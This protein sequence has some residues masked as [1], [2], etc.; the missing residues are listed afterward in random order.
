M[1]R[2]PYQLS[3]GGAPRSRVFNKKVRLEI[4]RKLLGEFGSSPRFLEDGCN[5]GKF[6][7]CADRASTVGGVDDFDEEEEGDDWEAVL[8]EGGWDRVHSR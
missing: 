5:R 1:G 3:Y 4:G 8:E 7:R 2:T 6:E